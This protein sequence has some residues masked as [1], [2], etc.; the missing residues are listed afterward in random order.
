MPSRASGASRSCCFALCFRLGKVTCSAMSVQYSDYRSID[1]T[2]FDAVVVGCGFAGSVVAHEL[3]DRADM[4]VLIIEKRSHIGGN[5][6]DEIDPAGVLVH[7]YGPHIFHTDNNRV[8]TYLRRFSGWIGYQHKVLADW[9]G[10]YLPVPFNKNSMETAFGDRAPHLIE[11]LVDTFG[12]ECKVSV[13]ELRAQEDPEL[14]EIGDFVYKN[15][16]L[17]YTQKQWG[18]SPDEVD[19]SITAR[20]PVY[21]SRDNRYFQD[22]YQGMPAM[23][24][25]KL[26]ENMLDHENIEVCLNTEAES[27]FDLVFEDGSED[28][29]I[30]EIRLHDRAFTGPIVFTGPLDELFLAR[31]GRL[32][33]RSLDFVYETFNEEHHFPCATVN[34]T[35]TQDYTRVTEFKHM[36]RQRCPK[37]T[38]VKEYP[39]AYTD[40]SKQT[41]YYAIIN[42]ENDAHYARYRRLT[43]SLP[44]FHPLGRLAEYRYYNMDE[45]VG[46]ALELSD[47]LVAQHNAAAC[48]P[49]DSE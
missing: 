39:R 41:P 4:R 22:Q 16:F 18:V 24:Y 30:K 38:I 36:T 40:P 28:A 1:I 37:T 3:A 43:E 45:I 19:P 13:N 46:H 31:F 27:V 9:Y 48:A 14:A 34:Y 33:Y 17:Y 12:D 49:Q 8:F 5:M 32:P 25:T 47:T 35:V 15:V 29:R 2:E 10:T 6:Y 21:I 11:K 20:V 42:K 26:F 44:N 23:G 7:R